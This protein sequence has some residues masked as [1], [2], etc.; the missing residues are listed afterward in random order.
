MKKYG[1]PY[2]SNYN[3]QFYNDSISP[4]SLPFFGSVNEIETHKKQ[5][6]WFS[7]VKIRGYSVWLDTVMYNCGYGNVYD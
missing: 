1:I 7:A 4:V 6:V 3:E 2:L 5:E